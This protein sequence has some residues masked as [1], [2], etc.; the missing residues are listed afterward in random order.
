M[1]IF[2]CVLCAC[3]HSR[4]HLTHVE[5]TIIFLVNFLLSQNELE[6]MAEE[7]ID[8]ILRSLQTLKQSQEDGQ[9]VIKRHLDQLEKDAAVGQEN[10][11][12]RVVKKLKEDQTFVFKKKGNEKQYIFNDNI[13]DQFVATVKQLELVDLPEGAQ[14]DAVDKAKDELKQGLEMIAARQKRIKVADRSEYGWATVDKYEQDQLAADEEDAKR[15]EKAEK[16][17]GSKAAKR[18]KVTSTSRSDSGRRQQS[19]PME[20]VRRF[21]VPGPV[22]SG[23]PPP[24]RHSHID[25]GHWGHVGTVWRWDTLKQLVPS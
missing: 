1:R 9:S 17:A 18:K 16:S 5:A 14:R 4:R 3:V 10:A 20:P 15:L 23:Q 24:C 25:R 12:Q 6:T 7:K 11:T 2:K 8:E 19:R 22:N 13:R 21:P